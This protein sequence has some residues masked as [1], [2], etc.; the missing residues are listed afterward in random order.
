MFPAVR[1]LV[2]G[3]TTPS[4][5][6]IPVF[7]FIFDR[8]STVEFDPR[9]VFIRIVPYLIVQNGF[10]V[11]CYVS[12]NG[13][14]GE[15]FWFLREGMR[16][17]LGWVVV[18]ASTCKLDTPGKNDTDSCDSGEECSAVHAVVLAQVGKCFLG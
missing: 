10:F 12:S 11:F 8:C 18:T 7:S 13:L 6:V 1:I 5:H 2:Y 4:S 17:L 15:L 14:V 16:C 3:S 9:I